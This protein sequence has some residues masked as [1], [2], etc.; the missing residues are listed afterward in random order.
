LGL[1]GGTAMA[2]QFMLR[3][4]DGVIASILGAAYGETNASL[5][6]IMSTKRVGMRMGVDNQ[7]RLIIICI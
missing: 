4:G 7:M 6:I 5:P 2:D 3:I 1:V